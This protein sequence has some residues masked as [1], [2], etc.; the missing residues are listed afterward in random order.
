MII[1]QA[2][3]T[4]SRLESEKNLECA[5]D[6]AAGIPH[7]RAELQRLTECLSDAVSKKVSAKVLLK[8][9]VIHFDVWLV[10]DF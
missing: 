6:D 5:I 8:G 1:H 2:R 9:Q 4:E 3:L 7:R 10:V